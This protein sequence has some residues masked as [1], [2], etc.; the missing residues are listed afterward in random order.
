MGPMYKIC[1]LYLISIQSYE[2][3]KWAK[4]FRNFPDQKISTKFYFLQDIKTFQ[5][6]HAS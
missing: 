1:A 6:I 2:P 5:E 4:E 3:L